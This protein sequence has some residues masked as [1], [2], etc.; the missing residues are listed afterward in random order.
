[1]HYLKIINDQ[2]V[3][4]IDGM[5]NIPEDATPIEQDEYLNAIEHLNKG[6]TIAIEND[7]M[8][9]V[10]ETKTLDTLKL[11]KSNAFN[12]KTQETIFAGYQ[13][14]ALGTAHHY[15]AK[16]RDQANMIAS[17]TDSYNPN[18]AT[19]WTTPF[20]CRDDAGVWALRPHT[21]DQIRQAGKDGK[22]A[23]TDAINHNANKQAAIFSAADQAALDNITYD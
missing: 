16:D 8:V 2:P 11:E 4:Y 18:N 14:N 13:S 1:M 22:A 5:T 12:I 6:G 15:P 23:I 20:W 17:V 19:D 21:A 3:F 10:P 7:T 9:L